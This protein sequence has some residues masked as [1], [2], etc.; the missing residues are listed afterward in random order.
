V[1]N[2]NWLLGEEPPGVRAINVGEDQPKEDWIESIDAPRP[3]VPGAKQIYIGPYTAIGDHVAGVLYCPAD[4]NGNLKING[5]DKLP[6]IIY[7][8]QY[9]YSTGFS[10][11]YDK[12]GRRGTTEL[13]A[14]LVKRGFA[15]LAIDMY[16]FGTRIE[17]ARN[18]YKRYP[19]WSKMGKM[20]R[21]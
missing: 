11:G 13:F 5:N 10:K 4:D 8:H 2:L 12:D 1:S 6:V 14:A 19:H 21:D 18:F 20:V 9:A 15:V 7:S 3:I 17:E 16:G